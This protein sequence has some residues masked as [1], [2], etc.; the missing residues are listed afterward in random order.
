MA[1]H[2]PEYAPTQAPLRLLLTLVLA[3]RGAPPSDHDAAAPVPSGVVPSGVVPSGVVI[4]IDGT[5]PTHSINPLYMGCHSDSGFG[6]QARPW[7]PC[8]WCSPA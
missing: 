8:L 6:Q 3:V 7:L 4:A 5:A 1:T 2:P